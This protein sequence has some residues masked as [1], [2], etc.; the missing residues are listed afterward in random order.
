MGRSKLDNLKK[1]TLNTFFDVCK[2]FELIAGVDYTYNAQSNIVKFNNGS[3][4]I[5]KDLFQYPSDRNFDSLGSLEITAAFIDEANQVTEKAKQIV[6]SRLRYKL[7][8]YNL[9]PKL[10]LTC[11]PAKNWVYSNFYK[12]QKEN[13]LPEYR[14]FIQA[15]VDDNKH[16]SKHYK[17]Q[18][19]KLHNDRD[20]ETG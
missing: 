10:L 18:L 13:R 17:E 12:P 2:E 6:S 8:E 16:I 4:I 3:E 14:K 1:T 15:L 5:L 7:D 19:L 11:N 9:T 20:W